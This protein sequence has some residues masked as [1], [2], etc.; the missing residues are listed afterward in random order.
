M[1]WLNHRLRPKAILGPALAVAAVFV[2][3]AG[4]LAGAMP[5]STPAAAVAPAA[6]A[7]AADAP[8]GA[9]PDQ[10]SALGPYDV[11]GPSGPLGP[12]G[13]LGQPGTS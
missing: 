9:Q 1:S 12:H 2:A 10:P 13:P 11:L 3:T 7:P 6:V 4:P 5:A 8:A